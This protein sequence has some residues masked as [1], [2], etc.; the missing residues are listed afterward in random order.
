[1]VLAY[2]SPLGASLY[3]QLVILNSSPADIVPVGFAAHSMVDA[4]GSPAQTL[5][6]NHRQKAAGTVVE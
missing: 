5:G 1:M 2:G 4:S 3:R 6:S